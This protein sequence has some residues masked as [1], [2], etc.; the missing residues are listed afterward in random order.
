MARTQ[1][2]WWD[3]AT[4]TCLVVLPH[5]INPQPPPPQEAS[6]KEF[7]SRP[8]N[9]EV[10]EKH[11]RKEAKQAIQLQEKMRALEFRDKARGGGGGFPVI[12]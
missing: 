12:T 7:L 10:V 4:S 8:E 11:Q 6:F 5:P 1:E 9:R 3:V 2:R